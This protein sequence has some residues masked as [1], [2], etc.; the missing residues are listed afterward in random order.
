MGKADVCGCKSGKGWCS[1]SSPPGCGATCSTSGKQECPN[2]GRRRTQVDGLNS[3]TTWLRRRTQVDACGCKSGEGW[4]SGSSPPGCGATCSTS[5]KQECPEHQATVEELEQCIESS[6]GQIIGAASG[7][8]LAAALAWSKRDLL[9]ADQRNLSAEQAEQAAVRMDTP[10]GLPRQVIQA[11]SAPQDILGS[12]GRF[13]V[14]VIEYVTHESTH[15]LAAPAHS[16]PVIDS[17]P[18]GD[19]LVALEHRTDARGDLWIQCRSTQS[20][21]STPGWIA[22]ETPW[23][24]KE[25]HL[26]SAG[27]AL[28]SRVGMPRDCPDPVAPG[29]S[30][31]LGAGFR[32][33]PRPEFVL[34]R[35]ENH[36]FGGKHWSTA[37]TGA[38]ITERSIHAPTPMYS[39]CPCPPVFHSHSSPPR[40]LHAACL[41]R[42]VA[43]AGR[44]NEWCV[45]EP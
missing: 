13:L 19:V 27:P 23:K 10:D 24:D 26:F 18:K 41:Y 9:R 8:L 6:I 39:V 3:S 36:S 40:T 2:Q 11:V 44:Q 22:V 1:G 30:I 21:L 17:K 32:E 38:K 33:V 34:S 35:Y 42:S 25:H 4:C 45:K 16:T 37:F 43:C 15:V 29:R 7:L 5:G 20:P 14:P 28:P 31:I 12:D